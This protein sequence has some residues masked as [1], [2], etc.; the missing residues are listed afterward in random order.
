[1]RVHLKLY[2]EHSDRS[3]HGDKISLTLCVPPKLSGSRSICGVTWTIV[4]CLGKRDSKPVMELV[5]IVIGSSVADLFQSLVLREFRFT[6]RVT[7]YTES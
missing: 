3:G 1:M 7:A 2:V 4:C 5:G 6:I